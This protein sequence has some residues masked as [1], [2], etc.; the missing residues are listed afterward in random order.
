MGLRR[1]AKSDIAARDVTV[2]AE[3]L[4]AQAIIAGTDIVDMAGEPIGIGRVDASN[5]PHAVIGC[6]QGQSRSFRIDARIETDPDVEGAGGEDGTRLRM[7][8]G[9]DRMSRSAAYSAETGAQTRQGSEQGSSRPHDYVSPIYG[10]G[11]SR[12]PRR[13]EINYFRPMPR[14]CLVTGG[15]GFIGRH[16]VAA[17]LARGDAVRV[18]DP[19]SW[20]GPIPPGLDFRLG[21]ILDPDALAKAMAG[22]RW[23]F[24][25]AADPNL[26]S[27]DPDHFDRLNHQGTRRVLEAAARTGIERFVHCSTESILKNSRAPESAAPI[28]EAAEIGIDDVPG[29]YCRSKLRAE[30]AAREAAAAGLP[31][32]IVNPTMPIGP[33]DLT[34]TPPTRMLRDF[35]NGKIPAYLDCGLNLVDVRDAAWGHILAA[36]KGRLGERYI[37]GGANV[38]LGGLLARLEALSGCSMPRR[39]I[40]YGL[41]Y[42]AALVSEGLAYLT[43][44]PPAAPL[45]GVRLARTSL[46]FDC[47]KAK[48]ELGWQ[49]RD[50]DDSLKAAI[51]DLA[52]R[53][54]WRRAREA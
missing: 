30:W 8:S 27:A 15:C 50:L 34:L 53:G 49:P 28:D 25:L 12:I 13:Q 1:H 18:L 39:R 46:A 7:G 19:Q 9:D 16:L 17:L 48:Q 26:W 20:P 52:A 36:E 22:V 38:T 37:L 3:D 54:L 35:L 40:P 51:A 42:M 43:K 29:P 33:G 47:R 4:P 24:H 6:D 21:S 31:V 45:T 5:L 23:V 2:E 10:G 44:R 32:V 14:I 11:S 41:A